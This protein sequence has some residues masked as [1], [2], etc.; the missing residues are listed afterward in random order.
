MLVAYSMIKVAGC[1]HPY[2]YNEAGSA[3]QD[4]YSMPQFAYVAWMSALEM[5]WLR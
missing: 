5:G 3:V 1:K 2:L 4:W